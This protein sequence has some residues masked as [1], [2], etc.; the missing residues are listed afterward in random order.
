MIKFEEVTKEYKGM[1]ALEDVSFQALP[2]RVT[3]LVGPNGSG[4]STAFRILLGLTKP[5]K[6]KATVFEKLYNQLYPNPILKVGVLLDGIGPLPERRGID[7][8]RWMAISNGIGRA[9]VDEV[10]QFVNLTAAKSK[11]IHQ[12]SLGMKQRLGIAAAMLGDPEVIILDEPMNGLDPEGIRWIREF[13]K[14][15]AGEGR[16]FLVASHLMKE[17]EDTV[18]DVTVLVYGKVLYTG[19]LHGMLNN[20]MSLEDAYFSL[21]QTGN[22]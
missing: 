6:G 15:E 7:Y 9:R 12:Y 20:H 4:K 11:R 21:T 13:I 22:N 2:G 17:L 10:L 18:D 5:T 19:P 16:T 1:M 14:K 3:G 8:L